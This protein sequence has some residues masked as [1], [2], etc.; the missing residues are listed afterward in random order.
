MWVQTP[1]GKSENTRTHG[2][3]EPPPPPPTHR[4]PDK[5]RRRDYYREKGGCNRTCVNC[6]VNKMHVLSEARMRRFRADSHVCSSVGARRRRE[7]QQADVVFPACDVSTV[8]THYGRGRF[9]QRQTRQTN[10]TS[11]LAYTW[12]RAL[13]STCKLLS[14]RPRF[15]T[16]FL[17]CV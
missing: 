6:R 3:T 16:Y 2:W 4:P 12:S 14:K 15:P 11:Q 17:F 9:P 10:K 1:G 5:K 13:S 8:Q 7:E